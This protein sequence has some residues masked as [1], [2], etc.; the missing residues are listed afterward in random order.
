MTAGPGGTL[1]SIIPIEMTGDR[2][3]TDPAYGRY[4]EQ[5]HRDIRDEVA[6]ASSYGR[7]AA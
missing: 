1:K 3:R 4:Y 5:V 7:K 2:E 6:K